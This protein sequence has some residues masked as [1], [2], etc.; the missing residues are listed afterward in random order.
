[1][2]QSKVPTCYWGKYI[3]TAT[4][5]IN[6]IPSRVLQGQSP[7]EVIFGNI[8][9]YADLRTFGSLC[10]AYTLTQNRGKFEPRAKACVFLGYPQGQKGYK[11]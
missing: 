6:R 7:Y 1:M 3:L 11:L 10:Y 4:Y 8:P 5:L 9:N 2:F